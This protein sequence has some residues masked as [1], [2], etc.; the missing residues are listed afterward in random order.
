MVKTASTDPTVLSSTSVLSREFFGPSED[1]FG[2][3]PKCFDAPYPEVIQ[4]L[5]IGEILSIYYGM[6]TNCWQYS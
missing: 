4:I 2:L 6:V 1:L 5:N 3:V